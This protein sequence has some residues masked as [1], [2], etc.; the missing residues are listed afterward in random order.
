M[1]KLMLTV[2]FVLISSQSYAQEPGSKDVCEQLNLAAKTIM[3]IRQ[4]GGSANEMMKIANKSE[5]LKH[6]VIDAF[7][8]PRYS[9]GEYQKSCVDEFK[10]KWYLLCIKSIGGSGI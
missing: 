10:N 2:I 6:I 8:S 4:I 1:K 3:E 5:I 7:N 9:T